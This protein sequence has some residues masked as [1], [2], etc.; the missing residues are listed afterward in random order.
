[1][2]RT[3][4][5]MII[6]ASATATLASCATMPQQAASRTPDTWEGLER[7]QRPGLDTVYL[8]PGAT[9]NAY[10]RIL[11]DPIEVSFDK[12][13]DPDGDRARLESVDPEKIRRD[14][15]EIARDV[16]REELE[17]RGGYALVTEPGPDV[18][19]VSP[20]IVDLYI[21]APEHRGPGI[22]HTYVVDAGEMTLVADLLDSQTNTLLA[23]VS[24][25]EQGR[26]VTGQFQIANRV[27]NTAEARRA[28]GGWA[29]ALRN[30]LDRAKQ[31]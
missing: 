6:A 29:R 19:R 28:I 8:R 24:D 20:K 11:L 27:T 21:N 13:W 14:L 17:Q 31:P 30:A 18:L 5:I 23:H 3:L 7:V 16:F 1:M 12:N 15:A 26:D 25:R 10:R 2:I 9:L 22:V 4:R